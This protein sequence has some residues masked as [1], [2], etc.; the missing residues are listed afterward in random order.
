MYRKYLTPSNEG[1]ELDTSQYG[2]DITLAGDVVPGTDHLPTPIVQ[3][4]VAQS[5]EGDKVIV[6]DLGTQNEFKREKE[7]ADKQNGVHEIECSIELFGAD[8]LQQLFAFKAAL[9]SYGGLVKRSG[10]KLTEESVKCLAI[11]MRHLCNDFPMIALESMG[12]VDRFDF[13]NESVGEGFKAL[14]AR[15]MAWLR[16]VLKRVREWIMRWIDRIP[17][18]RA[19]VLY[20]KETAKAR[21]NGMTAI[22]AKEPLTLKNKRIQAEPVSENK[23]GISSRLATM[24]Q[25]NGRIDL[26]VQPELGVMRYWTAT[27]IPAVNRLV[28]EAAALLLE[29]R[30]QQYVNPEFYKTYLTEMEKIV[31]LH[32]TGLSLDVV[33][34][35]DI[36]YIIKD[37]SI[38]PIVVPEIE[39]GLVEVEIPSYAQQVQ[40]YERYEVFLD[41]LER[42]LNVGDKLVSTYDKLSVN[43]EGK[44]SALQEAS[45]DAQ[46]VGDVV[47]KMISDLDL[48]VGDKGL[49]G[50][51]RY[52][53]GFSDDNFTINFAFLKL[54]GRAEK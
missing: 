15:L 3:D 45:I 51:L 17:V 36:P 26:Q 33:L 37:N 50:M 16:G 24:L 34:H 11:G 47:G 43:I 38:T 29:M 19:E 22:R 32:L 23:A 9:E 1:I 35:G 54:S 41:E 53:N 30:P 40:H 48:F 7:Q 28:N 13:S 31:N 46:L 5:N 21:S 49:G 20:L 27:V 2:V 52:M 8:D 14:L 4:S 6:D 18:R 10:N 25:L 42:F 39:E 44:L 12:A